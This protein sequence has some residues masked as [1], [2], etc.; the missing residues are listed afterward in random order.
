MT[1]IGEVNSDFLTWRRFDHMI[2]S[3]IFSSLT[4]EIMGQIIGYQTSNTTWVALD[5]IFAAS[6][7]ARIMQLRL[8][9]QTTQKGSLPIMEYILK[10]KTIIDNLAAIGEPVAE[11]DQ[12]LRLFAGFGA[13]YNLIVTS[14]TTC[15]DDL[16][17]HSVHS[18]LLSH[19][20]ILHFQNSTAE[21]EVISTHITTQ[22]HP[23]QSR[24]YH[25]RKP[26]SSFNS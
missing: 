19:E 11:R 6:S 22:D 17:L 3:W 7:K 10:M 24:K 15:E 2:L 26:S 5:K 4:P 20:Q 18:I 14:L 25:T 12:I 16:I 8:A 1:A 13:D 9:F 23:Q 21:D